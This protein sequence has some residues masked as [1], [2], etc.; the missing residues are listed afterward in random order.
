M[1]WLRE[2]RVAREQA[3]ADHRR[4]Q[5]RRFWTIAVLAGLGLVVS[6]I[7]VLVSWLA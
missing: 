1:E 6:A 2:K 7:G 4:T 5:T 3:E